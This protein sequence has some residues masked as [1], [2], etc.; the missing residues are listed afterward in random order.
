M[1]AQPYCLLPRLPFKKIDTNTF[2]ID[3]TL[4]MTAFLHRLRLNLIYGGEGPKSFPGILRLMDEEISPKNHGMPFCDS[5]NGQMLY[6]A[7]LLM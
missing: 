4:A 1:P 5:S 2:A 6:H 7:V 3:G